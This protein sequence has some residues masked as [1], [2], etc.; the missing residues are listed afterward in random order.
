MDYETGKQFERMEQI[1]ADIDERLQ[2][3]E[4]TI[5]SMKLPKQNKKTETI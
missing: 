3:I 5:K 4:E 2:K 1:F